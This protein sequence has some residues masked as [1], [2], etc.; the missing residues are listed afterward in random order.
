M[1]IEDRVYQVDRTGRITSVRHGSVTKDDVIYDTKGSGT[2]CHIYAKSDSGEKTLVKELYGVQSFCIVDN[3]IYFCAYVDRDDNGNW[4]S[5]IYRANLSGGDKMEVSQ[6]FA[7]T[8]SQMYYFENEGKIYGEYHPT[9]WKN[10]YGQAILIGRDGALSVI[11]DFGARSGRTTT[12]NDMMQIVAAKG[13]G[14]I[15]MWSDCLWNGGGE[16]KGALWSKAVSLDASH[17]TP[18]TTYEKEEK[19]SEAETEGGTVVV[20]PIEGEAIP[21]ETSS[22]KETIQAETDAVVR[23]LAPTQ[24]EPE[25]ETAAPSKAPAG[26]TEADEIQI[27]PLG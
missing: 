1:S 9:P 13:S 24:S 23:P 16:I 20:K 10:A 11:N 26:T 19:T 5:Q 21:R 22:V 3:S 2:S 8:V 27:I 17:L 12:G 4:Y 14:L 15:C 7:G 6:R 18:L 25:V